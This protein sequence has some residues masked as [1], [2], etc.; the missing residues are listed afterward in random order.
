MEAQEK[1]YQDG[2][3]SG[4]FL[5]QY[6]PELATIIQETSRPA[7]ARSEYASGLLVGHELYVLEHP[8]ERGEPATAATPPEKNTPE[9]NFIKGFNS[10]YS[11]S[12]S[13]PELARVIIIPQ[14][15]PGDY[16]NGL[17]AGKQQHDKEVKEWLNQFSKGSPAKDERDQDKDR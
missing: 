1:Q 13:E 11:L 14:K 5:A 3:N 9:Q 16:H 8:A 7:Q 6:A 17:T 4:Y 12:R 2:V 10:G 15:T